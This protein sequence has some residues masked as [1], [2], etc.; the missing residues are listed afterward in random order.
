MRSGNPG[1]PEVTIARDP[2]GR[3][4]LT[5]HST[6]TPLGWVVF[7]EQPLEEAFELLIQLNDIIIAERAIIPLVNRAGS[8][9]ALSNRLRP[10]NIALGVGFEYNY[11]NIANWNTVDGA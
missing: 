8:V 2:K 10:E 1:S 3:E 5:S 6:I 4:V 11:W 7:I 9:Y